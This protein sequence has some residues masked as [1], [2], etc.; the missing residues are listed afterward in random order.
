[1]EKGDKSRCDV[2][3]E[4][5]VAKSTVSLLCFKKSMIRKAVESQKF[6]PHRK[7]VRGAKHK[8]IEEALLLWFKQA[9][10]M[11]VPISGPILQ[12]KTK[13]L[14]LVLGH[15]EFHCS[16]GWL[17]R[18]KAR[19]NIAFRHS[20]HVCLLRYANVR[21]VWKRLSISSKFDNQLK[22]N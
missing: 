20:Y 8:D 12:A 11:N 1:M 5:S 22:A 7:N 14:D 17:E 13:E 15:C 3:K 10:T 9:R 18:F 16:S 19:N 2:A 4:F 6:S 21:K